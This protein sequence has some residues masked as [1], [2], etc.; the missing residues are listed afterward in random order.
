MVH[1]LY[2]KDRPSPAL[3]NITDNTGANPFANIATSTLS[4]LGSIPTQIH[5]ALSGALDASDPDF[6]PMPS[7]GDFNGEDVVR[8]SEAANEWMA[9]MLVTVGVRTIFSFALCSL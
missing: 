7:L 5:G 6:V 3:V 1:Q 8:M 2:I 4:A 9:F